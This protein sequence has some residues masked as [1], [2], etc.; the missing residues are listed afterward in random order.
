[1]ETLAAL[2]LTHLGSPIM[3]DGIVIVQPSAR[4]VIVA[5]RPRFGCYSRDRTEV[6]AKSSHCQENSDIILVLGRVQAHLSRWFPKLPGVPVRAEET[7]K[8]TYMKLWSHSD[9]HIFRL[10][11]CFFLLCRLYPFIVVNRRLRLS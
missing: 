10:P 5:S 6:R 8:L 4:D 1:M 11:V 9:R 2:A 7:W 3:P